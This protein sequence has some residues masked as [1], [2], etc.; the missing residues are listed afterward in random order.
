M[1][2]LVLRPVYFLLFTPFSLL[3]RMVTDPLHR[4]WDPSASDYWHYSRQPGDR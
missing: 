3:V 4:R 1:W 2:G